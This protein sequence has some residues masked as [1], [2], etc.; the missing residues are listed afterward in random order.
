MPDDILDLLKEPSQ[1]SVPD[2]IAVFNFLKGK[3]RNA[4]ENPDKVDM[5][6]FSIRAYIDHAGE[7]VARKPRKN[8]DD[9]EDDYEDYTAALK[10]IESEPSG[11]EKSK[12]RK[13]NKKPM[14]R[15]EK[16]KAKPQEPSRSPSPSE[17]IGTP[18]SPQ[19]KFKEMYGE[20]KNV[21]FRDLW[22]FGSPPPGASTTRQNLPSL[23]VLKRGVRMSFKFSKP[24][25]ESDQERLESP[26]DYVVKREEEDSHD[27]DEEMETRCLFKKIPFDRDE[28]SGDDTG[29]GESE[30]ESEG[31]SDGEHEGEGEIEGEGDQSNEHGIGSDAENQDVVDEHRYDTPVSSDDDEL[32]I[33]PPK[34]RRGQPQADKGDAEREKSTSKRYETRRGASQ[35][36]EQSNLGDLLPFDTFGL[37]N[38]FLYYR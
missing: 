2:R 35:A 12:K 30:N 37:A 17:Q 31:E 4:L 23:P 36:A 14:Q 8:H 34:K 33:P 27:S 1:M 5:Q 3:Q 15:S 7:T 28:N 38:P 18:S 16:K 11:T 20:Q 29:E 19:V 32:P 22:T 13:R 24:S 21:E 10:A 9:D 25:P 6:T 26:R